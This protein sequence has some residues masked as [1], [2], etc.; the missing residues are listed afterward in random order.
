MKVS[1]CKVYTVI[2]TTLTFI[3]VRFFVRIVDC[4]FPYINIDK[5]HYKHI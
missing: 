4:V 3:I 5:Y 1:I 2:V